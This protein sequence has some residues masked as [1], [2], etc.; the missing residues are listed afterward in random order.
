M[1]CAYVSISSVA[2]AKE[3]TPNGDE[4]RRNNMDQWSILVDILFDRMDMGAK[5]KE[6]KMIPLVAKQTKPLRTKKNY[7]DTTSFVK[8]T[9]FTKETVSL[10]DNNMHHAERVLVDY[11][12]D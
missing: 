9:C 5:D 6:R 12:H 11:Q 3:K 7:Y 2:Y 1:S 8:N 4:N 10:K